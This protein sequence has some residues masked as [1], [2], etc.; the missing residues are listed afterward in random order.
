MKT[1]ILSSLFAFCFLPLVVRGQ[2]EVLDSKRTWN[3]LRDLKDY[4]AGR[5][6]LWESTRGKITI[7]TNDADYVIITGIQ[8]DPNT[9]IDFGASFPMP[10]VEGKNI[11]M[12]LIEMD[13]QWP[14]A[15][16][17]IKLTF[18]SSTSALNNVGVWLNCNSGSQQLYIGSFSSATSFPISVSSTDQETLKIVYKPD[19]EKIFVSYGGSTYEGDADVNPKLFSLSGD[20][21]D[22]FQINRFKMMI[23]L[24][25]DE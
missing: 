21:F 7:P 14:S 12:I 15:Q 6:K 18:E 17:D 16:G 11:E 22:I 20:A 3:L 4:E 13:F 25:E 1:L 9:D 10:N 8:D 5:L 24:E 2:T 23:L 19:M